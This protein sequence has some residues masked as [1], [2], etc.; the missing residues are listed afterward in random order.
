MKDINYFNVKIAIKDKEANL[1]TN[2]IP[3][4]NF[5][6]EETIVY[7][8]ANPTFRLEEY[9]SPITLTFNVKKP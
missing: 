8:N 9:P 3:I 6:H 7:P 4:P 5:R 2:R 1:Y